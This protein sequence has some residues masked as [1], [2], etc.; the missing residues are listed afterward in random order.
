[1][2]EQKIAE[3]QKITGIREIIERLLKEKKSFYD[4]SELRAVLKNVIIEIEDK[5][6]DGGYIYRG[7]PKCYDI[8][9]SNLCRQRYSEDNIRY[10]ESVAKE[11]DLAFVED[12]LIELAQRHHR[13][14]NS[15]VLNREETLDEVQHWGAETNRI[16]FTKRLEVALFFACFGNYDKDG[17]IVL[18]KKKSVRKKLQRPKRPRMRVKAQES[19]FI[20]EPSGIVEPDDEILIPSKFK[21]IILK[22][23]NRLSP[24]VNVYAMYGDIFGFVK[25]SKEYRKVYFRFVGAFSLIRDVVL[26]DS[27]DENKLR[28]AIKHYKELIQEMPFIS[29]LYRG[30]GIAYSNLREIDHAI[31]CFE[32]ALS[33]R[34]DDY[35]SLMC[36]GTANLNMAGLSTNISDRKKFASRSLDI[37]NKVIEE[38]KILLVV[39]LVGCYINRGKAH[40]HL[41]NYELAIQDF[42]KAI[43]I[44]QSK[45]NNEETSDTPIIEQA[46]C[47]A[48]YFL[49]EALL[50]WDG[51]KLLHRLD[52]RPKTEFI[53][54]ITILNKFETAKKV[55]TDAKNFDSSVY[56]KI[57]GPVTG[58]QGFKKKGIK[59]PDDIV[60]LLL[61]R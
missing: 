45:P 36:L 49:G 23:L 51:K 29:D 58:K 18:K 22:C 13:T 12:T 3:V 19:V 16:D 40:I 43:H 4:K 61:P 37:F 54:K 52:E 9:S 8:V 42:D 26:S 14:G 56:R 31:N 5:I 57:V 44:I 30:C 48:C 47:E 24:P 6:D 55:L 2:K 41:V 25:F 28:K 10:F 7:E 17:R 15:K 1:M 34:P 46:E 11:V 60:D 38:N 59:L 32:K 50:C 39:S 53:H 35:K 27:R 20:V 21:C 33:W